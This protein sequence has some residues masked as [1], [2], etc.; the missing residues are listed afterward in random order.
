MKGLFTSDAAQG[1][2]SLEIPKQDI[3]FGQQAGGVW[4]FSDTPPAIPTAKLSWDRR[5]MTWR[6]SRLGPEVLIGGI[7]LP[8]EGARLTTGDL[9]Q[10]GD[11]VF[12]FQKI[13]AEPI[14]HGTPLRDMIDL[15]DSQS[16]TIGRD[17]GQPEPEKLC[18]DADDLMI[19][20][21]HLKLQKTAEG[22]LAEDLSKTG[23]E[24]NGRLFGKTR[25]VYGDR[26]RI[27]NYLFEFGGNHLRRID[28][29]DV[30]TL[31][32]TNL[33]VEVPDRESGKPLR[34]LN[35][36]SLDIQTGEFIGILG[37][38]GQ[39]KSTLLNALCGIKP[40]SSGAVT[41]GG[42][43]V[44]DLIKIAPARSAMSHRMTSSIQS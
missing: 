4:G 41:I 21:E 29:L 2:L 31:Q 30:G 9:V 18:L 42:V 20:K 13:I 16:L 11:W 8:P 35:D 26:L 25:L 3:H 38:S 6:M 27:S 7:E 22:W 15:K 33:V 17:L 24:L 28:H 37:G 10:I 40:G 39:G 5:H 14:Y 43:P 1:G 23:T 34:I 36:V 19:S 44:G 32:A 12:C